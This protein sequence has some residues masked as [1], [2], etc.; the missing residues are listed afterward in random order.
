MTS[1]QRHQ[2]ET[3]TGRQFVHAAPSLSYSAQRFESLEGTA[4]GEEA[5]PSP[6]SGRGSRVGTGRHQRNIR[7]AGS[8]MFLDLRVPAACCCFEEG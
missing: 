2:S 1:R 8:P 5:S 3:R 4:F 6:V 7:C